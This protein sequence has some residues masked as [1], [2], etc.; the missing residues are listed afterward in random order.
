MRF[1]L[2]MAV[3]TATMARQA[4]GFSDFMLQLRFSFPLGSLGEQEQEQEQDQEQGREVAQHICELQV[5]LEEVVAYKVQRLWPLPPPV[6][7]MSPPCHPHVTPG[8]EAV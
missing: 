8:S 5:H 6:T 3:H 4:N 7:P 2:M 1:K